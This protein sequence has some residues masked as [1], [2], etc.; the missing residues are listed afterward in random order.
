MSVKPTSLEE[1]AAALRRAFQ[2]ERVRYAS[3]PDPFGRGD[4]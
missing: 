4:W 1:T 2:Q 3:S